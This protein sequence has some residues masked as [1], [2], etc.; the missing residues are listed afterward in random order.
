M[1]DPALDS[2]PPRER[3]I[4]DLLYSEGESTVAEIRGALP[5]EL[6][7]QAVRAM[8][9]RLEAKGFVKR[10]RAARGFV[11][12]PAVSQAKAKQ[13]ALKQLVRVFFGG[14]S[15][16][17]VSALLGMSDDLDEAEL[18]ELERMIANA[19]KERGR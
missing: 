15:A 9:T 11:F 2:L 5:V 7:N 10:R 16:G 17:A 1:E 18:E 4:V 12:S 3:Q 19:R 8:L 14:S 6:T 13:S